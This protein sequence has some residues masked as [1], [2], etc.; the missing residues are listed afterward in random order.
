MDIMM[1][2]VNGYEATRAIRAMNRTDAKCVPIVAM[3]ANAFADDV[4]LSA[5]VGHER[6]PCQAHRCRLAGARA[7]ALPQK[8]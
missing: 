3:S 7:G 4:G 6:P 2:N 8:T 5:R 1:P